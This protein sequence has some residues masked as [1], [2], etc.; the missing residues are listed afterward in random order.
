MDRIAG[1]LGA[2]CRF[3][4]RSPRFISLAL[5]SRFGADSVLI[6]Y[7]FSIRSVPIQSAFGERLVRTES[8]LNR[9]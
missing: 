5:F 1:A 6:Q 2:T 8:S 3:S 9:C 4:A 7:P